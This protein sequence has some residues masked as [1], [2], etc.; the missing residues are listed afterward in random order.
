M[1][2]SWG[3]ADEGTAP[4][5]PDAT[6]PALGGPPPPPSV[7]LPKGGGAIRGL[8][9]KFS[10]NPVTGTGS[11]TIPIATSPARSGFGPQ[12]ALSYDSG[13]GN[14]VFG[15]GWSLS[16]P[17]VTR[18]TDRGIPKYEDSGGP[19]S[20][21]FILSGAEDLV[22]ILEEKNG[23]WARPTP[24]TRTLPDGTK[25]KVERYRP[26]VEGLF[27]RIERWTGASGETH[28]R[29]L[30]RDNVT[31]LYGRTDESRIA[32]PHDA[33]RVFSWLI[34][35]SYDDRGNAVLYRYA[36]ENDDNVDTT[37]A[38][39]RNRTTRSRSTSR[40]LKRVQYGNR[41]PR[42]PEDDL[43]T[44]KDWLFEIVLDY[45]EADPLHP[46]AGVPWRCRQDPFSSYRS[47]FE[48]RTY[49]L[50]E[51]ILMVHQFPNEPDVGADCVVHS[52]DLDYR[53]TPIGLVPHLLDA[54]RLHAWIDSEVTPPAR[55]RV[56]RGGR[57]A[58]RPIRRHGR[59]REPASRCRWLTCAVDR[60]RR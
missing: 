6:P 29:S 44:R 25:W 40:H 57:P 47:G 59:H 31:S 14:G 52:T 36:E 7:T 48:V 49:R 33:E 32:D 39:E 27:A 5:H 30:S 4:D 3:A 19:S 12:L 34:C 23:K 58:D 42:R 28:W 17:S 45:G 2:S 60:P 54:H 38:H 1:A 43:R 56:H 50:C 11:L 46:D 21:V 15:F 10:A 41:T 53:R 16:L 22:P 18:R 55:A 8:G 26:R 13:A 20:D 24:P 35:E 9:E 37:S 51:R